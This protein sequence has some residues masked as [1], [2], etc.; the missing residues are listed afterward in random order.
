MPN[1]FL[2]YTDTKVETRH[3]IRLYYRYIDKVHIMFRFIH[4]N[5]SYTSDSEVTGRPEVHRD[6][7]NTDALR[8]EIDQKN[9]QIDAIR[10]R[11]QKM[12]RNAMQK[13][14]VYGIVV[15][16][17]RFSSRNCSFRFVRSKMAANC[18]QCNGSTFLQC[19]GSTSLQCNARTCL[20]ASM[21]N[22]IN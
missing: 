20:Y 17:C 5:C 21:C 22:G 19:N 6:G 18:M 14:F 15:F 16:S 11:L 10:A 12:E 7:S 1:E 4:R 2:T 13:C 8:V 9:A 3:P